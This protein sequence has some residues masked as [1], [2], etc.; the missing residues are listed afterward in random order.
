MPESDPRLPE[1]I[2][3]LAEIAHNLWWSWQIDARATFRYIDRVGWESSRHNPLELLR[4]VPPER[5]AACSQDPEFLARYDA[6]MRRFRG[7]AERH[8]TWFAGAHPELLDRPIAYF[9]AEFALHRSIPVYSGG[10]GVLAGDLCKV[11]SDLGVPVVAVG[12]FYHRGYF[13]QRLDRDGWQRDSDDPVSALPNPLVRLKNGEGEDSLVRLP[14]AGREVHVAAWRVMLGRVPVVLLDTDL[15]Q[16]EQA[17][18]E[19]TGRLYSGAAEWRLRQEWV[20][21]VGGVRVL[22]ALGLHPAV[23]HANEGHAAFMYVERLREFVA[24]G[25]SPEAAWHE[26]RRSSVFTTHTPV[27][28]GHDAF[29][30]SEVEKVAGP[31]WEPMG[32]TRSQFAGL[33]RRASNHDEFH[34]TVLALRMAGRVNGVAVRHGMETRRLWHEMWPDRA[35]ADVPIGHVTNGVHVASWISRPIRELLARRVAPEWSEEFDAFSGHEHWERVLTLDD[36]ELWAAHERSRQMLHWY[37]REEARHRWREY[38]KDPAKLSAAGAL[39]SPQALTLGFARRFATYKRA[40]LLFRDPDRL[41]RLL[42]DPRRP[43]QLVFSG[44][45]HPADEPG[46]RMLQRVFAAAQD[47][48]LEGRVAFLEDYDVH[49]ARRVVQGVDLW[50]NL[51]TVPMEACGTSG[52]K[53]AL[54]AVPQLSTLDGWWAEGFTGANGWAIPQAPPDADANAWDHEHLFQLLER[55]IV[56]CFYDREPNSVAPAWAAKMKHAIMTAG[57]RFSASRML[58]DY[59]RDYYVPAACGD[60]STAPAPTG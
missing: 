25:A 33:G 58:R 52:M 22:R 4:A 41:R 40:D 37:I 55:E 32:M 10:L 16:N 12:L 21:G 11:A 24:A 30:V 54:N 47:P 48:A 35:E 2:A 3:G 15:P 27:P 36:D 29:P 44:K 34:M 26:V 59:V 6:V 7:L 51:P 20:L 42:T 53:A 50:V 23:W 60:A 28:A 1:R 14:T 39:L 17:D 49:L 45:A 8:E 31:F 5:L 57:S 13:D 19:L 38:W 56:P 46:K 9:S 18:R 43:V